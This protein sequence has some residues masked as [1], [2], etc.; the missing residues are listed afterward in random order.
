V[1][2][3]IFG[4]C[5]EAPLSRKTKTSLSIA[6]AGRKVGHFSAGIAT[7][8]AKRK[9][10]LVV[11]TPKM[12]TSAGPCLRTIPQNVYAGNAGAISGDCVSTHDPENE[13]LM[14]GRSRRQPPS[15]LG[16]A[17][18]DLPQ[19][20]TSPYRRFI[21]WLKLLPPSRKAGTHSLG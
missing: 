16:A 21:Y 6:R 19:G 14:A 1:Q 8:H 4:G 7:H 12:D 18:A 17:R 11:G 5:I 20:V 13:A 3:A 2:D 15:P 10:L 9:L